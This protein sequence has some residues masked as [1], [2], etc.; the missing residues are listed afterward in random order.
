MEVQAQDQFEALG[1]PYTMSRQ[2]VDGLKIAYADEGQGE[3]ILFIHGMGSYAPAWKKN[4]AGLSAHYR[5]IV[6]DLPGYG[7]SSK[8]R[9]P[10]NMSF[11]ARKLLGLMDSLNI[12]QFHIAG[13]SM[14]AQIAMHM[15]LA[16]PDRVKSLMMMAP[17]G[18]ETFTEAEK[19][20]F[21]AMTPEQVAGVSDEQY[22]KN[23][24]LNFYEMPDDAEF[25]YTD[26]MAI[27]TDPQFPDYCHV[28][29]EGIRGMLNEPVFNQLPELDMPTLVLYGKQD[30]LI[31]NRYMHPQLNTESVAKLA[32]EQLPAA[33]VYLIEKAGHFVQFEQA[34]RVNELMQ[35]FL[36]K[37]N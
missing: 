19:Q 13:H 17:A 12:Q 31:P 36:T 22:R 4:V 9:Y 18:I 6:V 5:C 24:E 8:G 25:M 14:G 37:N 7:K 27:K 28:V 10:A 23:L 16:E 2:A 15:A 32:E 21:M 33:Q 3:P 29:V 30:K 34:A 20:L 11:H 1:Y 35:D 26:R